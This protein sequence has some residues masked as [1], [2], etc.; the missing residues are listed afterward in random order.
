MP[1]EMEE[2]EEM[3]ASLLCRFVCDRIVL[4]PGR[5]E[6]AALTV[7]R[8]SRLDEDRAIQE[9]DAYLRVTARAALGFFTPGAVYL[10]QITEVG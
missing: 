4:L 1:E 5:I 2:M 10:A 3:P 8:D 9:G 7:V 6:E